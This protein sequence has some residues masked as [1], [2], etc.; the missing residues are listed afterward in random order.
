M[1]SSLRRGWVD[2]IAEIL[3]NTGG[4]NG[5]RGATD[6]MYRTKLSYVHMKQYLKMMVENGL[7][8]YDTK[9][10]GGDGSGGAERGIYRMTDRGFKYLQQYTR[11]KVLAFPY[12]E[13]GKGRKKERETEKQGAL[14]LKVVFTRLEKQKE[15]RSASLKKKPAPAT[16]NVC[17]FEANCMSR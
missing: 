10:D 4:G 5:G 17:V 1:K 15:S 3:I 16:G 9:K 13:K 14:H 6:I 12:G 7:L 2:I 11:I 8:V